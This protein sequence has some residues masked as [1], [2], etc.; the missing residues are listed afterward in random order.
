MIKFK[1]RGQAAL[2]FLTTY[3][4]AFLVILIM[5]SALGYFGI[6]NPS[7]LL[8]NRCTFGIEFQCVDHQISATAGT[9]KLRMKNNIGEP[10]D[11]ASVVLSTDS[12]V[13]YS[14]TALEVNGVPSALPYTNWKSGDTL[15]FVWTACSGGSLLSG[16]KEKYLSQ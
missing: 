2:E 4:W 10:I 6:L 13:P 11:F 5:I 12:S 8:P 1:K 15:N 9:L 3:G 7:K 14:C 16:E